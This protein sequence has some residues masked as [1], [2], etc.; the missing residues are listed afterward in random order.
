MRNL[1]ARAFR[2][3]RE[4]LGSVPADAAPEAQRLVRLEGQVL[5]AAKRII[6]ERLSGMR[7]RGHGDLHLG[8]VLRTGSDFVIIDFEG[9]PARPL[10]ERR[11]KRSPLSDAAGM[12]RSF[13]YAAHAALLRVSERGAA[14]P[15][16]L[17][18][19]ER[20]VRFWRAW[21]SSAFLRAY[22][23]RMADTSLLP[24]GR[25]ELDLLLR[26]LLLEKS[27]YELRYELDHR[28][29]WVRIPV[30]GILELLERP[31]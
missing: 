28:P 8:Q 22:L 7:I 5:D 27:V 9:E 12:L 1:T 11:L 26:F 15:A 2:L 6:G 18:R 31:G 17:P 20:W 14:R 21:V 3:L 10:G 30:R 4:R 25:H 13:D 24:G 19:L 16:D 23:H 29:A